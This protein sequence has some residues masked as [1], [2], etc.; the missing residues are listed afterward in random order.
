MLGDGLYNSGDKGSFFKYN[1]AVLKLLDAINTGI[2]G[3]PGIDY[4]LIYTSYKATVAVGGCYAIGDLIQRVDIVNAAT[5]VVTSTVWFNETTGTTLAGGCIPVPIGNLTPYISPS[6]VN[7]NITAWLGSV[8]PTVGQKTMAA[9]L[10]VVIASDQTPVPISFPTG[11]HGF[12]STLNGVGVGIIP[13]GAYSVS[14]ATD[15][16]YTGTINGVGRFAENTYN[17]TA[18]EGKTLPAIP[19]VVTAG[20]MNIDIL[21]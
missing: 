18:L 19:W 3:L 4:E 10:P 14:F 2:A 9:S 5:G 1:Y 17:F 21:T 13:A 12:S 15:A 6:N 20:N 8:T 11:V 7:A 16:G